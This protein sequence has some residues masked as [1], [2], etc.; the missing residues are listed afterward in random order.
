MNGIKMEDCK[1]YVD[2]EKR[3]VVCVIACDPDAENPIR[4]DRLVIDFI[5]DNF[6]FPDIDF[7]SAVNYGK[8]YQALKMPKRFVGKAVCAEGDEWNEELGRKLAF[9]RAKDKCYKSFFKRANLFA[10]KIDQRL[11]QAM[12]MF[13]EM[14]VKLDENRDKL[15]DEIDEMLK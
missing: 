8:L 14:G 13:N 2:E 9:Y 15:L 11:N 12:D 3:T 6:Q 4:V 7:D 10:Q 5:M 1:F